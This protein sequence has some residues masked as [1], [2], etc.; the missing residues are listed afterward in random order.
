[1]KLRVKD[2]DFERNLLVVRQGKGGK[3]RTVPLPL[4]LKS[5]LGAQLEVARNTHAVDLQD[6][7]GAVYLMLSIVSGW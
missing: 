2:I 4:H 7:R 1:M 3:D 6:G 5:A